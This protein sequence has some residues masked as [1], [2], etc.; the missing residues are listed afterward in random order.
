MTPVD[1]EGIEEKARAGIRPIGM[2]E[3][4]MIYSPRLV[5][6]MCAERRALVEALSRVL[7]EVAEAERLEGCSV[8]DG[9]TWAEA[10]ALADCQ[11]ARK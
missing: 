7:G 8:L 11:E 3:D 5:L 9:A 10:S 2:P 6:E 1:W 4:L